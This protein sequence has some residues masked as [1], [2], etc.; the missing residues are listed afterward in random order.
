MGSKPVKPVRPPVVVEQVQNGSSVQTYYIN[1]AHRQDRRQNI[2]NELKKMNIHPYQRFDAIKHGFGALG[3]SKSHIK[4][5]ELGIQS[6]ADH[7]VV[8]EDDFQFLISPSEYANLLESL[9]TVHYDVVLLAYNAYDRNLRPT[10]HPL[11]R[12]IRDSRTASGYIVRRQYL[13]TLLYN[14]QE[15]ARFLEMSRK[16][17]RHACDI[18]WFPLQAVDKWFS[19]YKRAGKQRAGYSDIEKG[20][21]NYGL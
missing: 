14:F 4:C 7:V 8:F 15:G 2:E 13:P 1:L 12:S 20:Q 3:C 5:L 17:N 10:T 9:Q 18:Y 21:R 19:Y 16:E 6:G 11:L